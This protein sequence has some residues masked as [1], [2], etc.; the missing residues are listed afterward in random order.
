MEHY[1][2]VDLGASNGRVIVANFENNRFDFDIVHRFPNV[3][4][5]SNEGEMF[6][7][8]LR[9]FGDIKEG[10]RIAARKYEYIKSLGID[11]FGCDFGFIDDKGRL[12]GNPLHYRDEKQHKMSSELHKILPEKELFELSQGP[13]NRI[14]GIYKLFALQQMDAFEYKYG[15]HLLMIPDILNFLLTGKISNE[16]TN[17]TMTLLTSQKTRNWNLDICRKLGLRTDIFSSIVEPGTFLGPLKKSVCQELGINPI[18]VVIPATHDTASAIAGIPVVHPE[19]K[20]GFISLGTWALVGMERNEPV[21]DPS[22]VPIEWGNEGGTNGKT[23]LLKNLNGMW[24][25]QQCRNYWNRENTAGH[26]LS[27]DEITALADEAKDQNCS[28]D[29]NLE[30]FNGNQSNMP[31]VVVNYCRES[32][33]DVPETIGEIARCVY[34]SLAMTIAASYE[35]ILNVLDERLELLQIVGGG[36]QNHLVCQWIANVMGIPCICGPTETTA[37]GNFLF[38]LKASGNISTL[39]EGRKICADSSKLYQL[40]PQE[41]GHWQEQ[42]KHF[43]KIQA[44]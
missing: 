11:T 24:V 8:I 14:M 19:K 5:V 16:F 13:C 43:K 23:M 36:T 22:I 35:D 34:K 42:L 40:N 25:I 3:P 33:Q 29:V 17:A 38:Q 32:G 1:A 37:M 4:V 41:H 26:E 18:N 20:W 21:V 6:W 39:E 2:I 12:I 10:I 9:I 15:A 31:Q 7:D 28:F 44:R 30:V 27:W